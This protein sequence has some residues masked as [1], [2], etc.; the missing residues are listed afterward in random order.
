[1]KQSCGLLKI[2]FEGGAF[3]AGPHQQGAALLWVSRFSSRS[4][5]CERDTA[6]SY[7]VGSF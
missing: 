6:F 7:E 4:R 3:S 1:M 5:Y 2:S